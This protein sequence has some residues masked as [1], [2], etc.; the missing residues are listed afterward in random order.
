MK[1]LIRGIFNN[2]LIKGIIFHLRLSDFWADRALEY[3]RVTVTR[4]PQRFQF[5]KVFIFLVSQYKTYQNVIKNLHE[6]KY[7]TTQRLDTFLVLL[8]Q[9]NFLSIVTE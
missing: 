2:K 9:V 8:K 5:L 4:P 6:F 1:Q 7:I 3:T